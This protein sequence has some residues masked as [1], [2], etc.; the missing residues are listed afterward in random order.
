MPVLE[1]SIIWT[2]SDL[3]IVKVISY[4]F[5][6]IGLAAHKGAADYHCCGDEYQFHGVHLFLVDCS[7]LTA[8]QAPNSTAYQQSV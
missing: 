4:I 3:V 6:I 1:D 5:V 8:A 7:H 2:R